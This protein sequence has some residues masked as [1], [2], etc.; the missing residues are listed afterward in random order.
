MMVVTGNPWLEQMLVKYDASGVA[1]LIWKV[2]N[3]FLDKL[4]T[5][6]WGVP[7]IVLILVGGIYLTIRLGLLQVR[8]LP[9]ALKYMVKNEEDGHGEIT[10]FGALCTALSATIGTGNI[11]G[12]ATAIAAGGPGALF[13][14]EVAAFFGMATK[15]S[16]GL[17]AVKYRV[18]DK[19]NHALGGPFYYIERGMGSK[20]KWLAKMFAFFGVCVGLFGIGTFSQVNGI[21]SAVNTFFDPNNSWSVDIP[22]LGNYSWT[23]IIASLILSICV[24]AVL[25]GGVKRI[26]K[27]SQAIVPFMAIIYVVFCVTLLICNIGEVPAAVALIVKGAFNPKAVT[28]GVVG[29]VLIAMQKGIARGIFSNESGLG[30]A[31][32]AAAAAQTKEPVRQGLVSMTGTFIDTIVICTMTGLSIVLTGAWQVEGLEGVQ[33]T[34][35]AFNMGIPFLPERVTSFILMMCLVFFAFTT[36][37][38]W[39]YYSERCL[40]YLFGGK[41]KGI[42]V[43]RWLYILAVF[44]GPY[45]TVAAVWTI[46]DIFNGLMAIPNMIALFALSGV[47]VKETRDY[48][49]RLKD[50]TVSK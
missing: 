30:S 18:V 50:G 12:V 15:Y 17:L 28:G 39:D 11:V 16:E 2:F 4:D 24:A 22:L 1:D 45:M 42:M 6:V 47:V 8:K 32:I 48:A 27:V 38:G 19:D 20:W 41:K 21:S 44:I 26:S 25:I 10:S 9:L 23:V 34:G 36:I 29:T 46:A 3:V 49:K 37:L 13:W 40:E 43:Y 5:I 35:Y 14:M 7:L 33:V 31:P